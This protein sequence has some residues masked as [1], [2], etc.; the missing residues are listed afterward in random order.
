MTTTRLPAPPPS[1][2]GFTHI[3]VLGTGGFADV[4]L[5]SQDRPRR[6]VAVKVLLDS[7]VNPSLIAAFNAEADIMAALGAHPSILT[8]YQTGISADGR[9]YL[10]TEYCP[11]GF[12]ESF[13]TNP[14]SV[15]QVMQVGVKIASALESAHRVNVLHRDIKPA[16]IL[17]TSYGQ[18]VL[19]DFGIAA[20]LRQDSDGQL[21]AMSV[22]WTAPE[23]ITGATTGTVSTDVWG[24]AATLYSLLAG[25]S[26][27]ET[28]SSGENSREKLAKRI[29]KSRP[30]PWHR[31][32]VPP[33][34]TEFLTRALAK[35]PLERP[36]TML[37]FARGLNDVQ[38]TLRLT[39][40]PIELDSTSTRA[41]ID[42]SNTS[43]GT[44]VRSAVP[45]STARKRPTDSSRGGKVAG[46][47]NTRSTRR[48]SRSVSTARATG[49]LVFAVVALAGLATLFA[50]AILG[51]F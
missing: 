38:R 37:E 33:E 16:N 18:P 14:V 50:L 7:V 32:D 46:L 26:P 41:E 8:V 27:F 17:V 44:I 42:F 21:L 4:H 43:T 36:A 20:S 49:W 13:R 25:A 35:D 2:P 10:I 47:P 9:P 3:R 40:T 39:L 24:L 11:T 15:E 48:F 23:V 34:L 22:P 5:Y 28:E 19:S 12:G 45:V 6:D 51:V 31:T 29:V 1:I 30:T